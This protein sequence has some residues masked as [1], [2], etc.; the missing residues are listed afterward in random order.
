MMI[1]WLASCQNDSADL[2]N[3]PSD[4]DEK[5]DVNYTIPVDVAVRNLISY[6]DAED[7]NTRGEKRAIGS[8][9]VITPKRKI[10]RTAENIPNDSLLYV[11]NFGNE[12][13][14]AIL[15]ADSR[16]ETDILAIT[17]CGSISQNSIDNA[18]DSYGTEER[19]LFSGYPSSGPG[20]YTIPESGEEILIN[21]NTVN[22]YIEDEKD[23]LIGDFNPD[24]ASDDKPYEP[25]FE[26][27]AVLIHC[28][29]FAEESISGNCPGSETPP[30]PNNP[31]FPA[32][33]NIHDEPD[34]PGGV[35]KTVD[36]LFSSTWT[37]LD[38]RNPILA[39]YKRW[40]QSSPFND[41]FPSRFSF[42]YFKSKK[43]PAG[44]FPLAV[45]KILTLYEFPKNIYREGYKVNWAELKTQSR[46]LYPRE[47]YGDGR[48]SAAALLR[49]LSH[50]M[51]CWY[52]YEGTF[53]FPKEVVKYLR[54]AGYTNVR[55]N[56][57]SWDH[58]YAKLHG[59]V[60]LLIYSIPG[61][62]ITRA[63]SWNLDGYKIK[64]LEK[65]YLRYRLVNNRKELIDTIYESRNV[66]MV[67][68]DFGWSGRHNG[69]Y[70]SGLF[71]LNHPD[72]EPDS[73]AYCEG[74]TNYNHMLHVITY[75]RPK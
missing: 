63:H 71:K 15:A 65:K 23:S 48:A 74:G 4:K 9:A 25:G 56:K 3:M 40:N 36:E 11:V 13:G 20:F 31:D 33:P 16:I 14:Y 69:Y 34:E 1:P 19:P 73:P 38:Q 52:F 72:A 10:T 70:A 29:Q 2:V 42:K 18:V 60:P 8:V 17:D 49:Q 61:N 39:D 53:T 21:P 50:E 58:V 57:Y 68:C 59:N 66:Q 47:Y 41:R 43:A 27:E 24:G 6:L 55:D 37:V 28:I 30:G 7:R 12:E 45:A 62:D 32:N 5:K 22:L 75:D 67:H 54:R 46:T 64:R 26:E 35:D 51:N 44:C